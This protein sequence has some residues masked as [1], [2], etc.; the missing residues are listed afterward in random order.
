MAIFRIT[1]GF[2]GYNNFEDTFGSCQDHPLY[3]DYW[4]SKRIHTENIK[5]PMYLT[6]SYSYDHPST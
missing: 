3:D 6:G 2:A 5:V 1:E 4:G